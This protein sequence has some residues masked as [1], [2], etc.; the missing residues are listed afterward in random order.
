MSRLKP[1]TAYIYEKANNIWY[2]REFG[3]DPS[4]RIEIGRELVT[5]RE[6]YDQLWIDIFRLAK[7]NKILQEE[8]DRV[9]ML[10]HLLK[11][12]DTVAW[13]PV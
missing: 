8:L 7:Q 11:E 13:H 2:A 9:I 4:S 10:Y 3:A 5:A 1:N 6:E 12:E